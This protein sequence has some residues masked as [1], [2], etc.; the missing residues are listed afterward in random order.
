MKSKNKHTSY[1]HFLKDERFIEWKLFSTDELNSYWTEYLENHPEERVDFLLA[2]KHFRNIKLSSHQIPAE[3]K[4]QAIARLRQEVA[5]Y[6]RRRKIKR[7]FGYA[8]AAVAIL[9]ISTLFYFQMNNTEEN[10]RTAESLIVG[11]ELES[12]DIQLIT[13]NK[14]T[15]FQENVDISVTDEGK[16]QV[17]KG[18]DGQAHEPIEVD[19]KA[20]NRLVVPYGKRTTLTL[21]DGSK[22]WLNSGSVLEFPAQFHG[23]NREIHLSSGELYIEVSSDKHKPFLVH[24]RDFNVKVHGTAF[25]LSAYTDSPHS[26]VLVEGS[27]SLKSADHKELF[28]N[29]GEQ[30]VFSDNGSFDTRIVDVAHFTSWRKGHLE[31][32]KTP[33]TEVL[34]QIGRYYNLSFDYE[35]DVNLGKRTCTGKISLSENLDNVM[36]TISLLTN[37]KYMKENNRIYLIN[38]N[39]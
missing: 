34:L 17:K 14:T 24:T 36:E 18:K 2:E 6:S 7:Y 3:K 32:D 37:S 9:L 5:G 19:R 12:E 23:R 4:T 15:A 27:V 16:A 33:M 8:A 29:P 25:N 10:L 30:A 1:I 21:A 11:N 28:I 35:Q 39:E 38:N 13:S 20:L 31:F 26:V 22:V